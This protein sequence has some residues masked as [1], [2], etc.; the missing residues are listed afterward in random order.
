MGKLELL[1]KEYNKLRLELE[2][3]KI[4][5]RINQIKSEERHSNASGEIMDFNLSSRESYNGKIERELSSLNMYKEP[6]NENVHRE[7]INVN[8]HRESSNGNMHRESSHGNVHIESS[9]GNVHRE[10]SH[11]NVHNKSGNINVHRESSNGNV[12]RDSSIGNVHR[13]SSSD[14]VHRESSNGNTYSKSNINVHRESS[15]GNVHRES[16]NGNV[17]RESSNGNIY[18]KSSTSKLHRESSNGNMHR[19]SSNGNMHRESS[20][21]NMHR[22][23]CNDNVHISD[24]VMAVKKELARY[25][26]TT[27]ESPHPNFLTSQQQ[28]SNCHVIEECYKTEFS[29]VNTNLETQLSQNDNGKYERSLNL[30]H[31]KNSYQQNDVNS[32]TCKSMDKNN[33]F[34][35]MDGYENHLNDKQ[36]YENNFCNIN[37][38]KSPFSQNIELSPNDMV[39]KQHF[40]TSINQ[41]TDCHNDLGSSN[42][43]KRSIS[44]IAQ[45][46]EKYA[47]HISRASEDS[48]TCSDFALN[49]CHVRR[50]SF[51]DGKRNFDHQKKDSLYDAKNYNSTG[52]ASKSDRDQLYYYDSDGKQ[53][54]YELRKPSDQSADKNKLTAKSVDKKYLEIKEK[55]KKHVFSPNYISGRHSR[56]RSLMDPVV[57]EN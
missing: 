37:V 39:I 29:N 53:K 1:S 11:G 10:S 43:R 25:T 13:E 51:Y 26:N 23:S 12:H 52:D 55:A 44:P 28:D 47:I 48:K 21:G 36:K 9:H 18:S 42:K 40:K 16:S 38:S 22:E 45:I 41:S 15:N 3:A 35:V 56:T 14:N 8:L 31:N 34:S 50:K 5:L 27:S 19:E 4:E 32:F 54:L 33:L 30:A 20:N 2:N 46:K 57:E 6:F 49:N 24:Q 7:S 17:H